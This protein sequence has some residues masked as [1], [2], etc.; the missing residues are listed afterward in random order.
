M[1][2]HLHQLRLSGHHLKILDTATTPNSPRSSQWECE[3][4]ALQVAQ[5][6]DSFGAKERLHDR[7]D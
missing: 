4:H 7:Y 3:A 2:P 1:L 5:D 6:G